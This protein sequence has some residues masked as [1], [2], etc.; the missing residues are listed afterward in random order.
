MSTT[1]QL[2]VNLPPCVDSSGHRFK[3]TPGTTTPV[4]ERCGMVR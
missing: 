2:Y 3:I 4:C 1:T